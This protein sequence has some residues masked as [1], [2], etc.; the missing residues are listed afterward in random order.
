MLAAG[1]AVGL[2][3]SFGDSTSNETTCPIKHVVVIF[4]ENVTFDHY[5]GTYPHALNP[6][7][8]PPFTPR[9]GTPP[10]NGLTNTLLTDNPNEDNPERL[11]RAQA[12]TCDQN[13]NY[14]NEQLAYDDGLVDHF[15]QHTAGAGCTG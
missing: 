11:D 4:D 12:V 9:P 10:V 6:P 5:F 8:E 14:T 15:V 3:A 2:P 13:H 1:A 7:G